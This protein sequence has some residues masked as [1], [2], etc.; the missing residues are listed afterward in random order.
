MTD[1]NKLLAEL[2][3]SIPQ[4]VPNSTQATSADDNDDPFAD[5][6]EMLSASLAEVQQ[7]QQYEADLKARKRGF[8]GMSKEEVDF[9]NSRMAAFEEAR[10]WEPDGAISV[11]ALYQ[12]KCGCNRMV[13]S[14]YM[15]H[16]TSRVNKTTHRW[17]TTATAKFEAMPV[18]E[19]HKVETCPRC[20]IWE[21]DPRLMSELN[22]V[23]GV[24]D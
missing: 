8:H 2:E 6:E 18:K 5:L 11:W 7:R 16:Q 24:E 10:I 21:L 19:L 4:G 15:E 12:C 14:R 3:E 17:I 9:I 23:L 20:S 1:S 13:F 22:D